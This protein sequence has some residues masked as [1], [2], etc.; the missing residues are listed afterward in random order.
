M[1]YSY[2]SNGNLIFTT[3]AISYLYN[4]GCL[5]GQKYA[6][7][8]KCIYC[9]G[10]NYGQ[11]C[12]TSPQTPRCGQFCKTCDAT[13]TQCASCIAGQSP[14]DSNDL[15]CTLACQPTHKSCQLIDSVYSFSGC[16]DG[17]EFLNGECVQCPMNCKVCSSGECS[18]CIW[19]Y[20]LK[21]SFCFEDRNCMK[22]DYIYD[23]DGIPVDINCQQCDV[24]YFKKGTR[25]SSCQNEP[26][27]EKCFI[28][29]NAN[30]CKSCFATHQ[31]TADKKCVQNTAGCNSPCQTCLVTDPNYCTTCFYQYKLS[32]RI[33][34]GQC[35]CDQI[36]GYAE[37]NGKCLL[38]TIGDCQ[39]CTLKFGDCTSCDPLRNRIL[40]G[41]TCPCL[42]GYYDTGLEDK[43]CKQCYPS[44]YNCSGPFDTDCTDCGDPNVYHKQFFNGKCIC[45]LRT[46][47]INQSD[48]STLCQRK[49]TFRKNLACHPR[50]EKCQNPADSTSNQYCTMCI[51]EQIRVVSDDLKCICKNGYGED[52]IQDI[53][54]S[55]SQYQ[56]QECHYSC[57]RCNG[58]LS[59]NCTEC[60]SENN[61][62]LNSDN[63]CLCGSAYYDTGRNEVYCYLACFHSCTNCLTAGEDSC[64]ACP[65]T[66]APDRVGATFKCFCKD[67][68]YYSDQAQLECLECHFTCK[69]CNGIEKTNCLTCDLNYRQLI[70][71]KCECPFGY[72][73]VGEL[74]CQKCYYA[75][76]TCFGS[77][78]DN[79]ITC[80]NQSNRIVKANQCVCKDGHLEKQIGDQ[81]C[82]KCS[83]RCASCS[84]SI[85]NC[86][87]CP[88]FSFRDLGV[89]NSCLCPPKYL[90]QPEN[91]ICIACHNTCLTCS[92]GQ[93]NQCT[94]CISS[95]GRFLNNQGECQCSQKYFDSGLPEC[96]GIK[97]Q[98]FSAC[99]NL[100][101]ECKTSSTNCTSCQPEKYL[102]G[103]TCLC[104]TKLQGLKISTY[105]SQQFCSVCHY[106][107]LVCKG[108][109]SSECDSCWDQ[110]KRIQQGTTCT[111]QPNYF[112][113]GIAK[114]A[115]CNFRC[116][117]CAVLDTQCLSCPP[118]SLR[119]LIQS[120]C[121]CPS[122]YYDDGMNIICQKCHYSCL[123]CSQ[124]AAKCMTCSTTAQR[125]FNSIVNSCS[126]N[127]SYFDNGIEVCQQCHYSCLN[128]QGQN[129]NQCKTCIDKN[130][131]FRVYNGGTC[132]CLI[133][134]YDDGSSGNCKKCS[135]Q[136]VTC[137]NYSTFCTSCPTTRHLNGNQCD[138]D[139][140][141][142]ESGQE[143]CYQCDKSCLNCITNST[144]CTECD[145]SQLRILNKITC[146]CQCQNGT[147]EINGVCQYC[148]ISCQ[149]CLNTGTNCTSCGLMKQLQNN[150]CICIQGTYETGIDKQ[151]QLCNQTCKTCINQANYCLT[152]S[153]ENFRILKVG[154]QCLCKDGYFESST[155][156]CIQCDLS[157]FTCQGSSKYCLSCDPA[158]HLQLSNQN[159][160]I[161]DSGYYFN[162]STKQC[163]A[164]NITCKE[165]QSVSQ[166]IECEPMTRYNDRDTFKCLC[167]DGFYETIEKMCQPCDMTCKTCVSQSTKCLTCESIH[168]RSFNNSNKCPCL[169][170]YFDVGI[171]MCQKCNDLCKTCQ[172]ISTQCLS[173]YET[174][175]VRILNSNICICKSGY[176]DNG[177]LICEMCSKSC[178]TCYGK[179]DYCTSCDLNMNRIDQSAIHK[180]PCQT[181]FFQDEN[182]VCQKCH[183]KCSGCISQADKCISCYVSNTSNRLTIS[184]NCN[185][186]DGYYDDGIQFQCQ[187]CSY[188]CKT[189]VQ[190]SYNCLICFS[191]LREGVPACNCK[192]GFFQNEQQ[193]CETCDNKCSTCEQIPSNCT[194]CKGN[195]LN[196]TC[197][198][199]EA[200]F[201]AGQPNCIQCD[202]QCLTCIG[203]QSHCLLCR[204]DRINIPV[205]KC[206]DGFY[207][208]YQSMDCLQCEQ[209]CQTC[210]LE[211]CLT[212][213]GN[214]VL[215]EEKICDCP[216]DSIS[217]IDTTW[218]SILIA[219][220]VAVIDVRFSDDLLSIKV[221]FDFSLNRNYFQSQFQEKICYKFLADETIKQLGN[222]PDCF[223]DQE[224]E[225]QIIIKLGSN[226][227]ILP[228]DKIIFINYS[229]GHIN[230]LAKI[231][232]FIFNYLNLPINLLPP[233]IEYDIP[234]YSLNPCDDNII[235]IKS[236]SQHGLRSIISIKWSYLLIGQSGNA[237]LE[238]FVLQQTNLQQLDLYIPI[239]TLPKQSSVTFLVEFQNFIKQKGFQQIQ[240][241]THSGQ[242]P[243][244]LWQGKKQYY[245]FEIISL[246]F[247]I[248]KKFCS[249][250]TQ[251]Q[252]DRSQ[253]Q[254]SL[255]EIHRNRSNSRS[256]RV[257]VSQIVS[258][259]FFEVNIEKYT[260]SP[261]TAYTFKMDT[262][263]TSTSFSSTQ[264]QTIEIIQGGLLCQFIGTKKIQNY[265]KESIINIQCKDLDTQY[266]WN[267]D[268]E[269]KIEV[270]CTDLTKN[271]FCTNSN[272][273][274][275]QVNKTDS[276][277]VIQKQSVKP[278]SIWCWNVIAF[279][280]GRQYYFKYNI[281]FL[282]NDFKILDVS[283]S[284]GYAIRPIN[285]YETLQF[286]FNISFEDRFYVL[287]YQIVII[288]NFEVI[289][290]LE[291][292]YFQYHFRL[293]DH[294]QY[295][296]QGNQFTLKFL[297]QFTNDI[298]PSQYD[299]SLTLNQP[300]ICQIKLG[301]QTLQALQ[302]SK[303][304]A[305]CDLQED[306]PYTYQFR[307]FM[308]IQD[309]KDFQ[310][311]RSDYSLILNNFQQT[312]AFE[313]YLPKSEG[314][315]LIQIMDSR[316][317]ITNIE[318]Y[319]NITEFK[320]NC[321]EFVLSNLSFKEKI[322]LLLEVAK[323]HYGQ[324]DCVRLADQLLKYTLSNFVSED[325]FEQLLVLQTQKLYKRIIIDQ[326]N[327]NST[328]RTLSQPDQKG[329]YDIQKKLILINHSTAQKNSSDDTIAYTKEFAKLK[330]FFHKILQTKTSLENQIQQN[331][332]FMNEL[333][334][335]SKESISNCLEAMILFIDD[336]FKKISQTSF[337]SEADKAEIFGLTEKLIKLIDDIALPANDKVQV[338]GYPF[339]LNGQQ[340]QYQTSKVT[341]D[342]FNQQLGLEK[343]L[344]DS[345]IVY[346]KKEQLK[347]HFNN[348]NIS[349]TQIYE[350]KAFL[351]Q[352]QLEIDQETQ[353]KTKLQNYLYKKQYVNYERLNTGYIVDMTE[354]FYCNETSLPAYNFQCVQYT[355]NGSLSLCTLLIQEQN[356]NQSIQISC[357]CYY[358]G[359]IFFTRQLNSSQ[360]TIEILEITTL[361]Q[362]QDSNCNLNNQ[363]YLLFHSIYI[364]FSIF[365]YY[366]LEKL[367]IPK[368]IESFYN[369][370]LQKKNIIK[371][372]DF[373]SILRIF[374]NS[375][376]F[377]H[378][379]VCLFYYDDPIITKSYRFL[380]L[381]IFLSI[382]IPLSFFETVLMIEKTFTSIMIVNY[383]ILLFLR[384]IFKL[385]EA[386]Y[387]FKGKYKT[388]II[389]LFF[390]IHIMSYFFLQYQYQ[391]KQ[392][393]ILDQKQLRQIVQLQY[394]N[395]NWWNYNI[396][397]CIF[398]PNIHFSKNCNIQLNH[399]INKNIRIKSIKIVCLFFYLAQQIGS[400]I[401]GQ[402][403]L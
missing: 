254:V 270:S 291:P 309:Y 145:Q 297:A 68:H 130:I 155:N 388:F 340:L 156:Q 372:Y 383:I 366:E 115:Q 281:V 317:S 35:V 39:T 5:I 185:C 332:I 276:I 280:Q 394:V 325:L 41:N 55:I 243:T 29:H 236:K 92:G 150:L 368:I 113:V 293:F 375:I 66:R 337:E 124:I 321:S 79:C 357:Q 241:Q 379:I 15:K 316:G 237:N 122:S 231:S 327:F 110:D 153:D 331:E 397:L 166:C 85:D 277:Q 174:E 89:N 102:N 296:N 203:N 132:Q 172:S 12:A 45:A 395:P 355:D 81:I 133:G 32:A 67:S 219:C 265:R 90:D 129:S 268:P 322:I 250:Q 225:K 343:D 144:T 301:Q 266:K 285:S 106:S 213:N 179:S 283:Y 393:L 20:T 311:Q 194:S 350:I 240:I 10:V 235:L 47:E 400:N 4:N 267:E 380:K 126:C 226:A 363:P 139:Q 154:N 33:I 218:C 255:V 86:D 6:G 262:Q 214:R 307:F 94:S 224:N 399:F 233:L 274:I 161:C 65:S 210:N 269:I 374:Q 16:I 44:C 216:L 299:L 56:F 99:S 204:G 308:N 223:L 189:C 58:P 329:C 7:I 326:T 260:L 30:E 333:L 101:Y 324:S 245:T 147:T 342:V 27:L 199:Q 87:S 384:I 253:Y 272:N 162:T 249:D 125:Y 177:S 239:Q 83:Y 37:L 310:T 105:L 165:C 175:Q 391:I 49:N 31:L 284:K 3:E 193:A 227:T 205:C 209:Y 157:C 339:T 28:C 131:S 303:I 93:S 74:Q 103:N 182:E 279:K 352:T 196:K 128:C 88:D 54:F 134:Y 238:D 367:E 346:V 403:Y 229:I 392:K 111:C 220:E 230:C 362:D 25:C 167:K 402:Q 302:T 18:Q 26:G 387:R 348:L 38:C 215:S 202:F 288:Y 381:S 306:S 198:C 344:M 282:D 389:I 72:Y 386:I 61:R 365:M 170:G 112:D 206:Q 42:Q 60:S 184:L 75:C 261:N 208:D 104:K 114:C 23:S 197:D 304:V 43:I 247:K 345:M 246:Y 248:L 377:I 356:N 385:F 312:N 289:K 328:R 251:I 141:Y 168:L 120:Q 181:N 330:Q 19:P 109:S 96:Q 376:K 119:V 34:P 256:S 207:D 318:S 152:C 222:N 21:S 378:E 396:E 171:E 97:L 200:Y 116:Q 258:D 143:K 364:V 257:K 107:C 95:T 264:N 242:L 1:I 195:R 263:E 46:I 164:C 217:H 48:G 369:K 36:G 77:Q 232:K 80:S 191:N 98:C 190:S 59:N 84:G 53:C 347:I 341:K 390:L 336:Q 373:Q 11:N 173:C 9:S 70:I 295:F 300:P 273:M 24:G 292:Q 63:K 252:K 123:T 71:S 335:Q 320:F 52:G 8:Y 13:N 135:V 361:Q 401:F 188:Q 140:S 40:I 315:V 176:F 148:D 358:M 158:F 221:L 62:Y 151:C 278:Y 178:L 163:E 186:K 82:L 398:G 108:R 334:F 313:M 371:F 14:L 121:L 211:G 319:Q 69:T 338:N 2:D 354:Y 183:L 138:C 50:C 275:F 349:K 212:C 244:I 180:C 159:K 259:N 160:C 294:Y 286:D 137:Q 353:V 149:T 57:L 169:D 22:Y 136:C 146:K 76:N 142:Y 360:R 305:N 78:I 359:I 100:C 298:M 351:N 382:L 287:E 127:D 290:I 17:Y 271:S 117:T 314:V 234:Q 370:N 323:N 118:Q 73:D 51:T 64:T 192:P 228:G 201:E 91:P 187:K